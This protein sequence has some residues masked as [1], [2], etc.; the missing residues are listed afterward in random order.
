MCKRIEIVGNT[1]LPSYESLN[2]IRLKAE[3]PVD[4]SVRF[5]AERHVLGCLCEVCLHWLLE[6]PSSA[7]SS[8]IAEMFLHGLV[9]LGASMIP[10]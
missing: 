9:L 8:A 10:E 3:P 4:Q 5:F 7:G 1:C 6:L 2:T